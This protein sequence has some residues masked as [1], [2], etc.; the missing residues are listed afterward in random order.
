MFR[1]YTAA[2]RLIFGRLVDALEDRG[3]AV[4]IDWPSGS[5]YVRIV[6]GDVPADRVSEVDD[7][8]SSLSPGCLVD[9]D[10]DD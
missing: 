9:V 6:V 7:V 3:F 5:D 10:N 8:M 4:E 2:H 1:C